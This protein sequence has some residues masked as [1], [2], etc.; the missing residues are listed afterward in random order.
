MTDEDLMKDLRIKIH[1]DYPHYK[2][3]VKP[4]FEEAKPKTSLDLLSTMEVITLFPF[5]LLMVLSTSLFRFVQSILL[6]D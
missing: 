4:L 6:R 5:W 2:D 3:R 1:T